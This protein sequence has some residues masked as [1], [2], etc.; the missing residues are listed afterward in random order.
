VSRAPGI[1]VL[2]HGGRRSP[3]AASVSYLRG[4]LAGRRLPRRVLPAA[5]PIVPQS[6]SADHRTQSHTH[7]AAIISAAEGRRPV[8]VVTESGSRS[9]WTSTTSRPR[10]RSRSPSRRHGTA[11]SRKPSATSWPA[12]RPRI[13]RQS[14]PSCRRRPGPWRSSSRRPGSHRQSQRDITPRRPS[15][16]GTRPDGLHTPSSPAGTKWTSGETDRARRETIRR[17]RQAAHG[18]GV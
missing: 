13:P 7:E 17:A 6:I 9:S 8:T 5:G 1:L 15:S 2:Q 14:P 3:P 11:R 4:P 10:S 16:S 12:S 18:L